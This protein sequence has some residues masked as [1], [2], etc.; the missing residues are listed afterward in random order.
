MNQSATDPPSPEPPHSSRVLLVFLFHLKKECGSTD[1]FLELA[2][3]A[4]R[5]K[6]GIDFVFT[7]IS[8]QG[9]AGQLRDLGATLHVIP[10]PWSNRAFSRSLMN[11][12]KEIRPDFANFHFCSSLNFTV[13]FWRLRK[14]GVRCLFHYHGEIRPVEDLKFRHRH[15]SRLRL[16]T[17]VV[18]RVICV[19]E[20]NRHF[21]EHHRIRTPMHVIYNGIGIGNYTRDGVRDDLRAELGIPED[22]FVLFFM[23][24]MIHRKGI[25]ILLQALRIVKTTHHNVALILI[26]GGDRSTYEGLA[27]E[28]GVAELVHFLGFLENYPYEAFVT[29]DVYVSASRAESFGLSIAEAQLMG[30]PVIATAVGGVPE[31]IDDG[32]TGLLVTSEAPAELACAILRLKEDPQL[33]TDMAANGPEWIRRKF[34]IRERVEEF[35]DLAQTTR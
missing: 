20:A 3:E 14:L 17:S 19:S 33:R 21:L 18:D 31:V 32:R 13:I 2:A 25:D 35:F 5:R 27:E 12:V 7:E 29:A 1:L 11:L 24:S 9:I 30:V 15:F 6:V 4:A 26:G 23:G 8:H 16:L 34:N 28:L 22:A 10:L